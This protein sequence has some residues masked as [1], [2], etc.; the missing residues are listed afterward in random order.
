MTPL[1]PYT[2]V[3]IDEA[4]TPSCL[5]L[6]ASL[7]TKIAADLGA[8]VIKV[9]PPG[10]DP[11]RRAAPLIAGKGAAEASAL[12]HFLNTGKESIV[13]DLAMAAGAASLERLLARADA[14]L[15]ETERAVSGAARVLL[16]VFPRQAPPGATPAS[17]F[18][19]LALGG[20]LDLI[21]APER[22]PLRL[23]GHQAAY[24]AGLAAFTALMTGLAGR[25]SDA[26]PATFDVS[27]L[28]VVLWVNWKAPAGAMML[29][30]APHRRGSDAEWQTVACADGHVALVF[31]E[32]DWP[33]LRD[34]VGD[35]M[36]QEERFAT[37]RG[38]RATRRALM[39][40]LAPWFATRSRAAIYAE[41]QLRGI[42]LGPVLSP[43]D[44]LDDAQF[45]ARDFIAAL[46]HPTLGTLRLPRL[47]LLWNGEAF[48]PR[49]A[50][51]LDEHREMAR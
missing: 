13:L 2:I 24:A 50:P 46:L 51:A 39:A 7:A 21:G 22:A 38:R 33:A 18:T 20:L 37:P 49:P 16:S 4:G 8:R 27:L 45:R 32:K 23:G 11:V 17:A 19:V 15:L 9:E 26:P 12:F 47:P 3:E 25:A 10:G 36:L 44:L 43:R 14:A 41:A 29:G 40:L 48:F 34:M 42:P 5:R 35:P 28:E 30:G 1:G 31:M 6:A